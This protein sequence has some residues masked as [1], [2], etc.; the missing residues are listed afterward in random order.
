MLSEGFREVQ[1]N[2]GAG[3]SGVLVTAC[4]CSQYIDAAV[5]D[6]N[7]VL[8]VSWLSCEFTIEIT[9]LS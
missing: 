3:K 6:L 7:I 9:D 1:V 5:F 4:H 2:D 8:F